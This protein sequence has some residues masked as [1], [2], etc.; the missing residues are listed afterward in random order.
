M[1]NTKVHID[2]SDMAGLDL[3]DLAYKRIEAL[4]REVQITRLIQE[5]LIQERHYDLLTINWSRL[6]KLIY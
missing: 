3:R 6:N 5:R 2:T 1:K 4:E